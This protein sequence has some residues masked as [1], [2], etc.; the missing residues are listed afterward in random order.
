MGAGDAEQGEG[1]SWHGCVQGASW[2]WEQGS[3]GVSSR[4]C[5]DGSVVCHA[6]WNLSSLQTGENKSVLPSLPSSFF[7]FFGGYSLEAF[8]GA[9]SVNKHIS[10]YRAST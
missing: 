9:S 1:R 7:F 6:V 8:V 2:A 10:I 4:S 5:Q 3:D